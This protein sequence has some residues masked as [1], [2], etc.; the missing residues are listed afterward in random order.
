MQTEIKKETTTGKD[1][2]CAEVKNAVTKYFK[3]I[4]RN[5]FQGLGF[6]EE[7]GEHQR[8]LMGYYSGGEWVQPSGPTREEVI[9]YFPLISDRVKTITFSI[10]RGSYSAQYDF[11]G[12][13][14]SEITDNNTDMS[15]YSRTSF[16]LGLK[17]RGLTPESKSKYTG[18]EIWAVEGKRMLFRNKKRVEKITNQAFLITQKILR[19]TEEIEAYAPRF[20]SIIERARNGLSGLND[21]VPVGLLRTYMFDYVSVGQGELVSNINFY[22]KNPQ[23][24]LAAQQARALFDSF[25]KGEKYVLGRAIDSAYWSDRTGSLMYSTGR[26]NTLG[27]LRLA[28]VDDFLDG[29]KNIIESKEEDLKLE[30]PPQIF[31]DFLYKILH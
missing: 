14:R 29:F 21:N 18:G 13:R 22:E 28:T 19:G 11:F 26:F 3:E 16:G 12:A 17:G 20:I 31:A 24:K 25:E 6:V 2:D 7:T 1:Q 5:Q 9:L 8:Y 15:I 4:N 23:W 10:R 30:Q 27:D